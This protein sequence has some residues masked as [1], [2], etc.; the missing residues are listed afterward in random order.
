MNEAKMSE[1][2]SRQTCS[3]VLR[4]ITDS[5]GHTQDVLNELERNMGQFFDSSS[6]DDAKGPIAA[7]AKNS[8]NGETIH[9]VVFGHG[10]K[11]SFH[12]LNQIA[13]LTSTQSSQLTRIMDQINTNL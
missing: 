8:L 11:F 3:S 5:I 6:E 7:E 9:E 2:G 13:H 1:P 4:D 12:T 10:D